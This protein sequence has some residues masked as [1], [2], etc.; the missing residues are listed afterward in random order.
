MHNV[1]TLNKLGRSS[2]QLM[3]HNGKDT[4]SSLYENS[5][6]TATKKKKP[7]AVEKYKY[8][9]VANRNRMHSF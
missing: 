7:F 3:T 6:Y 4:A 2:T 1:I 5:M 8:A 9:K